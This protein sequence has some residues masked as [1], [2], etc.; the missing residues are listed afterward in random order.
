MVDTTCLWK[1]HQVIW[2]SGHVVHY[3]SWDNI[4]NGPFPITI[5]KGLRGP[6]DKEKR[7]IGIHHSGGARSLCFIWWWPPCWHG[8]TWQETGCVHFCLC[9]CLI[10]LKDTRSQS[11]GSTLKTV[12]HPEAPHP[13]EQESF[14]LLSTSC[15]GSHFHTCCLRD[16]QTSKPWQCLQLLLLLYGS[17]S[18]SVAS[19]LESSSFA[20]EVFVSLSKV[21]KDESCVTASIFNWPLGSGHL[22]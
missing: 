12:S 2:I 18:C 15:W 9:V 5:M 22:I 8:I 13:T 14:H 1:M 10:L 3:L 7:L 21:S 17:V 11:W 20:L 4:C 6:L 19:S 16:M